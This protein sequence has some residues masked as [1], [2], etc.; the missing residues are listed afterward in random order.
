MPTVEEKW[1]REVLFILFF[2]LFYLLFSFRSNFRF[3]GRNLC[4]AMMVKKS[5]PHL[6]L[7]Y[8]IFV[9]PYLEAKRAAVA[10]RKSVV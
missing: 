10:D 9:S 5:L 1:K 6:R 4:R 2:I 7:S 8:F 3:F